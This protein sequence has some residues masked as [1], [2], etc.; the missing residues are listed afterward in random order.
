MPQDLVKGLYGC[1]SNSHHALQCGIRL[2]Y[3]R[4]TN[5]IIQDRVLC[6]P[7]AAG[8]HSLTQLSMPDKFAAD[9][10]GGP[11]LKQFEAPFFKG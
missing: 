10:P 4:Q 7:D 2:Y 5:C 11:R 8:R 3:L 1:S 9:L 6:I